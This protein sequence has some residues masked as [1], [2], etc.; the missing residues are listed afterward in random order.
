MYRLREWLPFSVAGSHNNNNN[1][2]NGGDN[3]FH[4]ELPEFPFSSKLFQNFFE[5]KSEIALYTRER[6][7]CHLHVG[8]CVNKREISPTLVVGF[9]LLDEIFLALT[10]QMYTR[11][12]LFL[13]GF[14]KIWM[15][16]W[17]RCTLSL[18]LI[19]R[20]DK[21]GTH[22]I[23]LYVERLMPIMLA[24]GTEPRPS[25]YTGPEPSQMIAVA[26]IITSSITDNTKLGEWIYSIQ[27]EKKRL[28][29]Y[30]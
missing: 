28:F 10:H 5:E 23:A 25:T 18:T 19:P 13:G 7:A 8:W 9:P 27:L 12:F 30:I 22:V 4:Q 29:I 6:V 15:F 21:Y 1:N 16:S 11:K 17:L 26:G 2:N 3:F 24:N 20:P 14:L